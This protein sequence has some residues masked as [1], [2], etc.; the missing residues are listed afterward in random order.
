MSSLIELDRE[1]LQELLAELDRRLAARGVAA[2]VYVV[3]GAAVALT[4]AVRRVTMD[5][6]AVAT[7]D[8]VYD[9]AAAIAAAHGLPPSWLN[10]AAAPWIP[11]RPTMGH[12]TEPGLQVVLAPPEHLLAM[13][14]VALRERDYP[15]IAALALMIGLRDAPV[16]DFERVLRIAY[17]DDDVLETVL[18]VR[19]DEDLDDEVS[20]RA[21]AVRRIVEHFAD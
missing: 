10:P 12:P 7:D 16:A 15:D 4:V 8:V 20:A 5:V 9:E 3:G 18:G 13:K 14:M 11:P 2:G 17:S 1:R 19:R 21:R 6:D